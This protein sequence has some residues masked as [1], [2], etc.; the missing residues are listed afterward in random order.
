[1]A[2]L[3]LA[4]I[5]ISFISLGL[6]D[7]LLGAAWPVMHADIHAPLAAAG[8][9]SMIITVGTIISS[10]FSDRLTRRFGAGVVTAVSVG[11]TAAALFGFSVSSSFWLLCVWALPYGLGAGAVDAALNNFVALHFKARHMSWLHCFWGVGASVGPYIM[12]ACLSNAQNW[13]AGYRTV[14][15]IQIALT[16]CLLLT[17]PLWKTKTA[18]DAVDADTPPLGLRDAL[19]V[20]GVKS[21]LLAF[22][23]YC[24]AENTVM[25][26]ACTY[27]NTTRG[28]DPET[29]ASI[30][31]L[32]YIG[33][34]IGRLI[35]GFVADR[36]TDKT[37]IRTGIAVLFVG[38]ALTA[39]PFADNLLS[40]FGVL[41][42][43]LGCAPI[44]PSIIHSTPYH[45]GADKSGAII[46]IEMAAAYAGSCLAPPLFGF[47]AQYI[48]TVWFPLYI[49]VFFALL[50]VMSERL[51]H[52]S[53]ELRS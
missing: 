8:A 32:F 53:K 1:M 33:M 51:N 49:A 31:S 41:V 37:L 45:F 17:L 43:G 36:T 38:V 7:G 21:L 35:S 28:F 40:V 16:T 15:L 44:Y 47:F 29:A 12:A 11:M 34:M 18:S 42:I 10:L 27:M 4:I 24:A 5:Y 46:G 26:W 23:A 52:S 14:S 30:G 19:R 2:S 39:L 50:L 22:F 9:I 13:A 3:L 25:V 6:P 20:R 48:S